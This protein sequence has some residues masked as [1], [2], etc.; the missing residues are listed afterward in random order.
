METPAPSQI[1]AI[2]QAVTYSSV[3]GVGSYAFCRWLE[4]SGPSVLHTAQYFVAVIVGLRLAVY[5]DLILPA[6]FWLMLTSLLAVP[7][8]WFHRRSGGASERPLAA[9]VTAN[10]SS[11]VSAFFGV[12]LYLLRG[13]QLLAGQP[14][15]VTILYFLGIIVFPTLAPLAFWMWKS[16]HIRPGIDEATS[17]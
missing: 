13:Q 2:V 11:S 5:T 7:G 8:G 3:V 10:F 16:S 15:H 14:D 17:E 6:L 9:F 12:A 1:V 4:R